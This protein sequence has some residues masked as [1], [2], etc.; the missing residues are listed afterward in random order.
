MAGEE[1][2]P[3]EA[4]AD[5]TKDQADQK[6]GSAGVWSYFLVRIAILSVTGAFIFVMGLFAFLGV[7]NSENAANITAALGSLFGVV[8]TLVGAYF[9]I[10]AS[11]DAQD[12]RRPRP[13]GPCRIRKKQP[14]AQC[15]SSE[16][17][18]RKLDPKYW[19]RHKHPRD[20]IP[21][22]HRQMPRGQPQRRGR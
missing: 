12:S 3:R 16:K 4:P 15:R 6:A 14:N 10:K 11:S 9:G 13:S 19:L 1:G 8:G 18:P 21:Q 7:F 22:R 2:T 5:Q 17:L 20:R